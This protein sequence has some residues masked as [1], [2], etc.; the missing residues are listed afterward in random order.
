VKQ[1][2]LIYNANDCEALEVV[3]KKLLQLQQLSQNPEQLPDIVSPDRD[4]FACGVAS[5]GEAKS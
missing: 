1:S 5:G 3:A 4:Y 2:L